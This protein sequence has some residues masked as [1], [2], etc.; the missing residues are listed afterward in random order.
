MTSEIIAILFSWAVLLS[1]YTDPGIIPKIVTKDKSFFIE[2][3][4]G[5]QEV[6]NVLGWYPSSGDIIYIHENLNTESLMNASIVVHE[7]VHYLQYKSG[8]LKVHDSKFDLD[9]HDCKYT[10]QYVEREAYG[11][12]KEFLLKNGVFGYAGT[13]M[14]L[15]S[16]ED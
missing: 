3:A 8:K 7:M 10:L 13:S 9:H 1:G 14:H 11:V 15:T 2:N 5:K 6:C 12:Q 16:C 4:C